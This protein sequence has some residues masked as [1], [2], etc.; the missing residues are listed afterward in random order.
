MNIPKKIYQVELWQECNNHCKYCYNKMTY[1]RQSPAFKIKSMNE[2]IRV[3][4]QDDFLNNYNSVGLIGGEFFQ[5]QMDD[6]A[7]E[8]KFFEIMNILKD[9]TLKGKIQQ[10]WIAATLIT[11]NQHQLWKMLDMFKDSI[12]PQGFVIMTSWDPVGRFHT[13]EAEQ[14]WIRNMKK[15]HDEY[16][17]FWVNTCS[18]FTGAYIDLYLKDPEFLNNFMNDYHTTIFVKPPTN[19][20]AGDE[21]NDYITLSHFKDAL[22]E[23]QRYNREEIPN[24]YPTQRQAQDFFYQLATKNPEIYNCFLNIEQRAD[25]LVTH[26]PDGMHENLRNKQSKQEVK[27]SPV[28]DHCKHITYYQIYSDN[29]N[30][31][32]CD[33]DLIYS[34]ILS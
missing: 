28:M 20:M 32:I 9:Y 1:F 7:V 15:I 3:I 34:T 26:R 33:R 6:P 17:M 14:S 19:V 13:P 31:V 8:E 12:P 22:E 10:I 23:R 4:T 25:M 27:D 21:K 24:W 29:N 11:E 18:I 30:C 5:G 16:P 2:V